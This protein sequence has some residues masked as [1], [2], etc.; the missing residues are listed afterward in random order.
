MLLVCVNLA[1]TVA[2]Q[3]PT[4]VVTRQEL[5]AEAFFAATLQWGTI[6]I[7]PSTDS[8]L[9]YR[10]MR[11]V[12]GPKSDSLMQ[13][14][15]A[16]PYQLARIASGE[17]QLVVRPED[18]QAFVGAALEVRVPACVRFL[19][20]EMV[21][22]GQIVVEGFRGDL[23]VLSHNGD[24]RATGLSG[25]ATIETLNGEI[26]ASFAT[27][28]RRAPI[29]LLSRNGGVGL[30]LPRGGTGTIDIETRSGAITS[31]LPLQ[32]TQLPG[33]VRS[34][35]YRPRRATLEL[36]TGGPFIRIMTLNGDVHVA[37]PR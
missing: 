14:H 25:P 9:H 33:E 11:D 5:G 21:R 27:T 34:A 35:Q 8:A 23:S 36:G 18:A 29:S 19:R 22:G 7:L 20:L 10:I 17:W 26:T 37:T 31:S 16:I 15:S 30:M 13:L 12:S 28:D 1:Y 6:R 32:V 24:V 2:A 4:G 3:A